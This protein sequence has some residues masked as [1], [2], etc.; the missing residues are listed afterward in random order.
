M[1]CKEGC[2]RAI[3]CVNGRWGLGELG[4]QNSRGLSVHVSMHYYPVQWGEGTS[5]LPSKHW[6]DISSPPIVPSAAPVQ[7][8][9]CSTSEL[10]SPVFTTL[11]WGDPSHLFHLVFKIR[12]FFWSRARRPCLTSCFLA[13]ARTTTCPRKWPI[14][15]GWSWG[16]W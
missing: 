16:R 5:L 12:V 9:G 6:P 1:T 8:R 13:G 2:K 10:I 4:K 7:C 11:P 14:V 15:W 3:V